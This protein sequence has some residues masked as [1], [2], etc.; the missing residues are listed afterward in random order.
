MNR[1]N[2][3]WPNLTHTW[4]PVTGC[5]RGCVYCYAKKIHDRFNKTPFSN[6]VFHPDRLND[7]GLKRKK[8]MT[9]FVGSMS[10]CEYWSYDQTQSILTLCQIHN[11]HT[12]MFL[13]KSAFYLPSQGWEIKYDYSNIMQGVTVEIP[14]NSL[15]SQQIKQIAQYRRP[16]VSIEPIAG[17][18]YEL[19]Q[20]IELVIVGAETG[21][22]KG[23]IIPQKTWIQSIIDNVPRGKIHWKP[24]M[25]PYLEQYGFEV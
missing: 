11:N 3:D 16:F 20:N 13:S 17:G 5:K 9:I 4:N 8:P 24:S 7:P 22:R 14:S 1:T 12:Y 25:K 19:P 2:I 15:M 6:I 18:I 21:N 23:K 10:D